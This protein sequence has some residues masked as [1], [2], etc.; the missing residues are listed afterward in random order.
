MSPLK[1]FSNI[2]A[3]FSLQNISTFLNLIILVPSTIWTYLSPILTNLKCAFEVLL[4]NQYSFSTQTGCEEL[5][6]VTRF[7]HNNAGGPSEHCA[8]CLAEVEEGEEIGELRCSHIFHQLCLESW[9][10]LKHMTCP[11]CRGSLAP[12]LSAAAAA[13]AA[14]AE[15][16]FGVEVLFFKFCSFRSDDEGHDSWWL[17]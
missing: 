15:A 5:V 3:L 11:L 12:P 4:H 9:I 16:D 7:E 6:R 14:T 10:R 2:L 8:V 1:I 17:R 13:A